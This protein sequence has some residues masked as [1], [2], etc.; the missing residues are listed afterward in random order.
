MVF[1]A[2]LLAGAA[3]AAVKDAVA[4]G[5]DEAEKDDD[6][7]DDNNDVDE[8]GKDEAADDSTDVKDGA[9]VEGAAAAGDAKGTSTSLP[10]GRGG[11]GGFWTAGSSLNTTCWCLSCLNLATACS[12]P[13]L[14]DS[15]AFIRSIRLR[16]LRRLART[17]AAWAAPMAAS[18]T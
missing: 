3:S 8:A 16:S 4:D 1:S 5:V 17:S 15:A 6:E 10:S 7:A 2:S 14:A 13:I 12:C 9:T 18:A 11:V